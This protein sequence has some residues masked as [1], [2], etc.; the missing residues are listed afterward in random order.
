VTASR[1]LVSDK[2]D[3]DSSRQRRE[4]AD[5]CRSLARQA[6]PTAAVTRAKIVRQLGTRFEAEIGTAEGRQRDNAHAHCGRQL[7]VDDAQTSSAPAVVT[8]LVIRTSPQR[9]Y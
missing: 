9:N 2:I 6:P 3:I 1:R 7:R 4:S 8:T 5:D